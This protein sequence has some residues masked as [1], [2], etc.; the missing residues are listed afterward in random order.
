MHA[1][2]SDWH[3]AQLDSTDRALCAYAEQ[4]TRAPRETGPKVIEGLRSSGLDDRSIH[5]ATQI[6]GFFNYINRVADALGVE[7]EVFVRNWGDTDGQA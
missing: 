1:I 4:L 2:A 7:P 3:Q 6:I 5:D